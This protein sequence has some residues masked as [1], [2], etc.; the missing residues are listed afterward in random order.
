M[1]IL[2]YI[3]STFVGNTY[4]FYCDCV[5]AIDVVGQVVDYKI[6][7][8]EIVLIVNVGAKQMHIGTNHPN[9]SIERVD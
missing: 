6:V 9:L 3:G 8:Q 4:H 2:Q 5:F 1:P 7:G